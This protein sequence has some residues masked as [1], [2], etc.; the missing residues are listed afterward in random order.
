MSW[1]EFFEIPHSSILWKYKNNQ[2]DLYLFC[3]YLRGVDIN[4]NNQVK[5]DY[6]NRIGHLPVI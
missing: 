6:I 4:R 3:L 5:L 2:F 1:L